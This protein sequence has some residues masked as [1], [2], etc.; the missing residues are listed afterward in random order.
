MIPVKVNLY[1]NSHDR[2]FVTDYHLINRIT[3]PKLKLVLRCVDADHARE[4]VDSV[5]LQHKNFYDESFFPLPFNQVVKFYDWKYNNRLRVS[6]LKI[7][8]PEDIIIVER[9][10]GD[11]VPPGTRFFCGQCGGVV[12]ESREFLEMPFSSYVW[13]GKCVKNEYTINDR[14]FVCS[15]C[16]KPMFF[17]KPFVLFADIKEYFKHQKDILQ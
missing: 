17:N 12:S 4:V 1:Y 14:G 15:H 10:V 6:K 5:I 11:I 2:D 16:N 3:D 8:V 13:K 7:K 9:T